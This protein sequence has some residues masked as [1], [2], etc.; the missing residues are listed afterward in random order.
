MV[1]GCAGSIVGAHT[2]VVRDI[3][4]NS[5]AVGH[6]AQVVKDNVAWVRKLTGPEGD[7]S[8]ISPI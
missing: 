6:P 1:S 3:P 8:K 4:E 5:L 7:P 2:V